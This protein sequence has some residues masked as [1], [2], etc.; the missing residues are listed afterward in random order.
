MEI[1]ELRIGNIIQTVYEEILEVININSEGLDYLDL[2]KPT[3]KKIERHGLKFCEPIP[4]TQEWLLK[5][6]FEPLPFANI[7][8]SYTKSIGRN[9]ILS[10]GNVSTPNE[11]IFLCEINATDDKKIDDA[12]CIRNYDYDKYTHVHQLQNLYFALTNEELIW[13]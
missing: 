13:K 2:R 6:G 1:K 4:L 3:Y 8:N 9:R 5:F 12:I 10:V 11:M 7:L